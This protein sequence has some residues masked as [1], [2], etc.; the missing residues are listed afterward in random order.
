MS[1]FFYGLTGRV[2]TRKDPFY[3][4]A[5]QEWNRAIQKFPMAIVYCRSNK[6]VSN[7]VIWSRRHCIPI[8]VRSGGHNYEGYS[9]GNN[10][11]VIDIS[12]L[13]SLKIRGNYLFAG[14]G[15]NNR[16][17]YDFVS[18]QGYPFPGG[19]CPT[20][21]LSGYAS[22]GGWGLSCRLMGLGCDNLVE[23][24]LVDADGRILTANSTQNK[25]LFWA[26]RGAGGGNFG[27][28]VSMV[29]RLPPKVRGVT[30]FEFYYPDT[31]QEKQSRF[32]S[33]WQ[34]W[35]KDLDERMSLQANIYHSR[36]E[37]FALWGRGLF[38]G[39][40]AEAQ[41]LL[42]PIVSLGGCRLTLEYLPFHDAIT[43]IGSIYP[44]SEK[45]QATGRFVISPLTSREIYETAGLIREIPPGS[46]YSS[47]NL[48][49]LGGR[50]S[51]KDPH[52][53]A[54]F[55]RSAEYIL[56]IQTVWEEAQYAP[57]NRRWLNRKFR[58]L[59]SVTQGSYVNFPY[60][61]LPDYMEA[62]Y[63]GNA[64][65]LRLAKKRYDPKNVFCFPQSIPP[66]GS[67][68]PPTSRPSF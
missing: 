57:E 68:I 38:Y 28:I 33:V 41:R 64:E 8:R 51:K 44:D 63:G 3:D 37:N 10:V 9:T 24:E 20:V 15:V 5:R 31:D 45:F 55:Y 52:E 49:A 21:G 27:V 2:V 6:D 32:L 47:L 1:Q 36:E 11:L 14:G 46:V 35:L 56:L 25:E 50:V 42:R 54:F 53:T 66:G 58:Y 34:S 40:E 18:S 23:L 16:Q 22:G 61:R 30:Y 12:D 7:A 17:V 60:S 29:F 67:P 13:N 26:C 19:T 65:R 62:Y 39:T 59:E 4:E 43:K 48:Y